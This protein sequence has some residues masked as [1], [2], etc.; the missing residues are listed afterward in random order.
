M[1]EKRGQWS[2]EVVGISLAIIVLLAM[3][4]F[5][6]LGIKGGWFKGIL[7]SIKNLLHFGRK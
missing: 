6:Y 5:I 1:V 7:D 3:I 2:N 4:G